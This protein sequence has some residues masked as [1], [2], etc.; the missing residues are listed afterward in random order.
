M[1][2]SLL[3]YWSISKFADRTASL[4]NQLKA[5]FLSQLIVSAGA[6]YSSLT[7]VVYLM[8][9]PTNRCSFAPRYA[10]VVV[11]ATIEPDE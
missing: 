7:T 10:A 9:M 3:K 2:H 8:Q 1:F 11:T 4:R 6:G 5:S